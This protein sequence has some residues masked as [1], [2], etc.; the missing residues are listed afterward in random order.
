VQLAINSVDYLVTNHV[1]VS[2]TILLS[3]RILVFSNT[4]IEAVTVEI[5]GIDQGSA[6]NV[7]GPLFVLPWDPLKFANGLHTIDVHAKVW[8]YAL[9]FILIQCRMLLFFRFK[10]F[11]VTSKSLIR[12]VA[13]SLSEK[14]LY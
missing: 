5:D 3:C 6:K 12:Q 10:S 13:C 4:S 7:E 1:T 8:F 9:S 14:R 2:L 11:E